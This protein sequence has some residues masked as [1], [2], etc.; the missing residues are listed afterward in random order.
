[1]SEEAEPRE[2][3]KQLLLSVQLPPPK[4][5]TPERERDEALELLRRTRASLISTAHAYA[6][7]LIM[8]NGSVTSAEVLDAM[9]AGGHGVALDTVDRRF[10]GAAFR[11]AGFVAVGRD[12][13]GSHKRTQP[14][15][16]LASMVPLTMPAGQAERVRSAEAEVEAAT[17]PARERLAAASEEAR[18]LRPAELDWIEPE[19]ALALDAAQ[20]RL[21]EAMGDWNSPAAAQARVQAKRAMRVAYGNLLDAAALTARRVRD[22]APGSGML[23]A[24]ALEAAVTACLP[25]SCWTCPLREEH[26]K[27]VL[28]GTES[29]GEN[30]R[31]VT[32]YR[33]ERPPPPGWCPL[34]MK[35]G[36]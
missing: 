31:R 5:P 24:D 21:R 36:A 12:Q 15:W 7:Q 23:G 34:R 32:A 14:R 30:H 35:G 33:G 20:E 27:E 9:R 26:M 29:A 6:A 8:K 1:M 28:C 10:M 13:T 16:T 2:R 19:E 25:T 3:A 18:A 11:K 22:W 17:A 4:K